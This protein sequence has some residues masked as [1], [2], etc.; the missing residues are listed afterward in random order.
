[1]GDQT[2]EELMQIFLAEMGEEVASTLKRISSV[3]VQPL[4]ESE[5]GSDLKN[6][7]LY[8]PPSDAGNQEGKDDKDVTQKPQFLSGTHSRHPSSIMDLFFP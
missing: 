4:P 2:T 5:G 7:S 3:F 6:V 1:M 8:T